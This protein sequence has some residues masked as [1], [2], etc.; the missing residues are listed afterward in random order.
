MLHRDFGR[1]G[2]KVTLLGF[3]AGHVGGPDQDDSE[4][5]RLLNGVLDAGC[6]L[7]DTARG[8]GLSEERIGKFLSHR[9][10]EFLLSSKCGY[11]VEGHEDWTGPCITAG[12]ERALKTMNTD[13]IDIMHLHSCPKEVL[14]RGEVIEALVTAKD[15]GKIRAAAYSGENEHR[16]Y[17]IE[18]GQFDSIQTSINI[19]EQRVIDE[20]LPTARTRGLGVIAKRPIANAFWRFTERPAGQYCEPY[21]ERAQA[22]GLTPGDLD[23]GEFALRFLASV[24]AVSSCIVG[25]SKLKHFEQ[26]AAQIAK[27]PLPDDVF[28]TTRELFKQHDNNWVGQV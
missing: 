2:L 17:A 28:N 10:D 23:W 20:A 11:S 27:G 21:W 16:A 15:A 24:R 8:Y 4:V 13:R 1:T 7:I 9:R 3:G 25:T 22:M 6:E 18:T 14:E 12:I 5:E 19:C 26:A